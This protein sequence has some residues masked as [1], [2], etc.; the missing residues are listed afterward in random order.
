M[1]QNLTVEFLNDTIILK[2]L[3]PY[4]W[5]GQHIDRF[6]ILIKSK[7]DEGVIE[8]INRNS[9]F[10]AVETYQH[11][12]IGYRKCTEFFIEIRAYNSTSNML[13][14]RFNV[15]G[16]YMYPEGNTLPMQLLILRY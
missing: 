13:P 1:E 15:S 3:P 6:N 10:S 8:E 14:K 12:L 9:T 2:W 7:D 16:R 4:L 5:I 11:S